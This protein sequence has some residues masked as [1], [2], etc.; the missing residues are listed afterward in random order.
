MIPKIHRQGSKT[1]GLIRY[2]YGPGTHEEHVDPRL[3]AA[4]DPLTPDPGRDPQATY[5][6]LQQ[7]LDQ[8]VEALPKQRRPDKHVWHLSVRAAPEDPV[9][10][11]E[12][13]AVIARRM[14]AATGIAPEG[15]EAACRWAA[16]RH[17]DDHIHIIAT[18]VRD[19]GRRPRRHNEARRAQ[20]ECR[21]I[22]A[23]YGLRRVT[24][25]DG[26]AAKHPS[27]A[28]RHKAE[29]LGQEAASRELLRE[30][31]RRALAG[32]ADEAEFFARLA[33]EGVRINKRLAPSGDALGYKVAI[34]GD[35]NGAGE[36]IW[37]SGSEL[38]SDLSLPRI[39][40]R[41]EATADMPEPPL[42]LERGG[43]S[44]PARARHFAT[45]ATDT[46]LTSMASRDDGTAAA[47]LVGVGEILDA[48]A[49]TSLGATRSE[50]RE[51]AQHFERAT[52]SH[53]RAKDKEMYALRRAANQIVHSG[54][55]LGRGQDGAAT[56]LVLD[57]MILAVIAAARW[58][59]ARSHAQQAEAAQ[60]AADH[61]RAAYQAT[62]AAP[63][64]ALRTYG[65]R[66]PAQAKQR[67]ANTVRTAV[68]HLADRL[69]AEPGWDALTAVLDQADRAGHDTA[70]LLT[71]ATV[72]R[73]LDSADSVSDVLVWR[74]HHLGYVTPPAS[75]PRSQRP[76]TAP[77]P[78][79][80]TA[81]VAH[82]VVNRPRRR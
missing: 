21:S 16:V 11:D 55:A 69:Q 47:Q 4:F 78:V 28:E 77:A 5:K 2:L 46:A 7:L 22:E 36:P 24:P 65:Q 35:R 60:R 56:A 8:P 17:A 38:A 30:H 49:Q 45:E 31:V 32:A 1:V 25:G 81:P 14:V 20:T 51:A 50:L 9:L 44:A 39:R 54:T 53:T 61:L 72:Q 68:P 6:Q 66:L 67:Y 42:S 43:A 63:L 3:V 80:A 15:D 75:A 33:A 26:T 48:L 27:S 58:H 12:D 64:A 37:Y 52:R 82:Q 71:K 79:P 70:A 13:W 73:E 18:L 57:V 74:L 29:R 40:K 34:V 23:D 10:S 62:T 41:F 19:D 59:A 76:R